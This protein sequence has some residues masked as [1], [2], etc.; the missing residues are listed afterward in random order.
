MSMAS[1]TSPSPSG[2]ILPISRVTRRPSSSLWR[3]SASAALKSISAR[4]GAGV[5]F[6]SLRAAFAASTALSMSSLPEAGTVPIMSEVSA[7]FLLSSVSP[8]AAFIHL[9]LIKLRKLAGMHVPSGGSISEQVAK[10]DEYIRAGIGG[11]GRAA[12]RSRGELVYNYVGKYGAV[13]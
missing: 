7:G 13:R 5:A 9:P 2:S 4:L 3:S 11:Q 8:V 1:G 12:L 6:Q 10:H